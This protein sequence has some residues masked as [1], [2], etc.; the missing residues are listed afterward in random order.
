MSAAARGKG[1]DMKMLVIFC[2]GTKMD[3]VRRLIDAHEVHGYTE[4]PE[5]LGS[6][7]TGKHL[8]T[9]AWPGTSS[10]VL[11]AVAA[12]KADE[13]VRALEALARSCS[14]EEG[15]RVLVLPVEKLI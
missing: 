2:A 14:A 5:V 13:L 1:S 7:V 9:R 15:M 4:I 6:G 10:V 8:G 11:T 12:P 3:E